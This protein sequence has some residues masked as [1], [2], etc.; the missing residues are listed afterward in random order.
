MISYWYVIW[1]LVKDLYAVID[2]FLGNRSLRRNP[3]VLLDFLKIIS[4]CSFKSNLESKTIP[5]C[6]LDSAKLTALWLKTKHGDWCLEFSTENNLLRLLSWIKIKVHLYW[7]AQVQS[8][9]KLLADL[10]MVSTAENRDASSTKNFGLDVK[11]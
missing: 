4:R 11:S 1:Y 9:F 10:D 7:S 2:D 6:F 3:F 8:L 5:G